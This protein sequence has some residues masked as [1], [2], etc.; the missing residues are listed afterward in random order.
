MNNDQ[1]K[2]LLQEFA[3]GK[4]SLEEAMEKLAMLP[5]VQHEGMCW[6]THRSLRTRFGEVILCSHKT[7]EQ[8]CAQVDT[9]MEHRC[10]IFGTRVSPELGTRLTEKYK[11]I[12]Y[13]A[14]A[15]TFAW[16][17]QS[18]APLKGTLAVVAAGASD[19]PVAEEATQT[20][21]FFGVEAERFYD[22]GVA[23]LHRLLDRLPKIREADV[24]IAVAGM[25]G[26]LP[27]VLGGLI[28]APLI[29]VP[30]SVGYGVHFGGLTPLVT[31]LN[32]C[33]EGIT[34]VN[35]DNGFGAACA[36]FRI[37]QKVQQ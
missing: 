17:I 35:I 21:K 2:S 16:Q 22:V 31:M 4:F 33:A 6:D 30:T 7:V 26:A 18:V 23:G 29:A 8:V 24:V 28:H 32:S 12:Q 37:L 20:A 15:R 27:S 25:E 1:I 10:N 5:F 19:L 3:G 11:Q 14:V 13:D 36:A 34:V 9:M